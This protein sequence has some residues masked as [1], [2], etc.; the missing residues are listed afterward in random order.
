MT[1]LRADE[2]D[3]FAMNKQDLVYGID[4]VYTVLGVLRDCN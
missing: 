2:K 4:S 1:K 3:A